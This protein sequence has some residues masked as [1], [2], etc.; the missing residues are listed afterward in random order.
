LLS[1]AAGGGPAFALAVA[2]FSLLPLFLSMSF[3][4]LS[5]LLLLSLRLL[6]VAP[7]ASVVVVAF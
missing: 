6:F 7:V 3:L 5:L 2:R 4:L 1:F